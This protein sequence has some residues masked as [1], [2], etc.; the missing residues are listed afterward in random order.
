MLALMQSRKDLD[1]NKWDYEYDD[2]NSDLEYKPFE[3]LLSTKEFKEL[4]GANADNSKLEETVTKRTYRRHE[5]LIPIYQKGKELIN[6]GMS[7]NEAA[8]QVG[9][10]QGMLSRFMR[11]Q[12]ANKT[13]GVKTRTKRRKKH[14]RVND[15]VKELIFKYHRMGWT[16][17]RISKKLKLHQTTVGR[18]VNEERPA[19]KVETKPNTYAKSLVSEIV[20]EIRSELKAEI[21]KELLGK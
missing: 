11:G 6:Q 19:T 7:H 16:N 9:I 2:K 13:V 15:H 18:I 21:L 4:Y 10:S 5:E 1:M 12:T 20:N 14:A 8:H 17:V 3:K